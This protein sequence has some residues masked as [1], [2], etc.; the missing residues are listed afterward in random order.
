M[1]RLTILVLVALCGMCAARVGPA[2]TSDTAIERPAGEKDM[3]GWA[4]SVYTPEQQARLGVD[5]FGK[6]AAPASPAAPA[7]PS[8]CK[9]HPV[10]PPPA[11]TSLPWYTIDL[12]EDPKTRWNAVLTQFSAGVRFRIFSCHTS[13][14]R[15]HSRTLTQ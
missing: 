1:T 7:A 2:W 14:T 10:Y 15:S 3:G 6:P 11:N 5:E 9:M 12:D 8:Q 13:L 4:A